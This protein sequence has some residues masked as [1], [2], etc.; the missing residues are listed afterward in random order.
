MLLEMTGGLPYIS[1][2]S[3]L[4]AYDLSLKPPVYRSCDFSVGIATRW[5]AGLRSSVRAI[6]PFFSIAYKLALGPKLPPTQWA[7][8][9]K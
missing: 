8:L 4:Q 2:L 1:E 7:L 3:V 9:L 6:V 5:T